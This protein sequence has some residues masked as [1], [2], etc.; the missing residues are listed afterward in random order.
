MSERYYRTDI[1]TKRLYQKIDTVFSTSGTDG[2][3]THDLSRVRRTLI[4]AELPFHIPPVSSS[5]R[6]A[7]QTGKQ[8][9]KILFIEKRESSDPLFPCG[10]WDLN[11]HAV[12]STR[13]LVLLVCQFRH[14]RMRFQKRKMQEMGLEPTLCCHNRHLKPARLP[15]RHS[16]AQMKL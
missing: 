7:V 1:D 3:R 10:R 12:A 13:S 2:V 6:L 5:P 15:F 9:R 11:P 14:F 16:C 8:S 4:P